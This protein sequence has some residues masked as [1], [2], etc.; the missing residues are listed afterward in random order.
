[1]SSA[2]SRCTTRTDHGWIAC[3]TDA[4]FLEKPQHYDLVLDLTLLRVRAPRHRAPGP[5]ARHQGERRAF[6]QVNLSPLHRALHLERRKTASSTCRSIQLNVVPEPLHAVDQ[7]RPY[8][9]ARRRH[10]RRR[11]CTLVLDVDGCVG[12]V[13]G[14]VLC[15]REALLWPLVRWQQQWCRWS[16]RPVVEVGSPCARERCRAH[17]VGVVLPAWCAPAGGGARRY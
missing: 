6:A 7:A 1:M 12:C 9:P 13:R 4:V 17:R 8:Y 14:R 11:A 16:V 2:S 10:E 3:T 15:L 5:A